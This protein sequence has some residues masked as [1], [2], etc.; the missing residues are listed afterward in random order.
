MRIAFGP[1]RLGEMVPGEFRPVTPDELKALRGQRAGRPSTGNL[2]LQQTL[3]HTMPAAGV[4][5]NPATTRLPRSPLRA[6]SARFL[7][8]ELRE[9][10]P[11]SEAAHH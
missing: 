1:V 9:G 6:I 10:K 5:E 8:E 7:P 3:A 2:P 11:R 4:R